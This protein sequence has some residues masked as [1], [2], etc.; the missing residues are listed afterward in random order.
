MDNTMNENDITDEILDKYIEEMRKVLGDEG[1]CSN[2]ITFDLER[3]KQG[4]VEVGRRGML[5]W[6]KAE[7][8]RENKLLCG[9]C[10]EVMEMYYT[11]QCF[12]CKDPKEVIDKDGA[13]N[14]YEACMIVNK[15]EEDFCKD[16]FIQ[17]IVDV[18]GGNDSYAK[19]FFNENDSN[20][21]LMNKYFE[22][23]KLWFISW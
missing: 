16:D 15:K 6:F 9:K 5:R 21:K 13:I 17:S 14:V 3:I 23:G 19:V 4:E 20:H 22:S 11:A 2:L 18:F 1:S 12:R 7:L 8:A 10:G